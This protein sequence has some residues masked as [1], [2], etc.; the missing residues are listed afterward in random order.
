MPSAKLVALVDA[1]ALANDCTAAYFAA[2]DDLFAEL[3]RLERVETVAQ[4]LLDWLEIMD[5]VPGENIR[6]KLRA[7]IADAGKEGGA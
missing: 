3:D 1:Y 6:N 4:Q 2:R 7:A 5:A